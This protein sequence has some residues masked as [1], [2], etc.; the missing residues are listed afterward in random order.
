MGR[1]GGRLCQFKRRRSL[2]NDLNLT[3]IGVFRQ[4]SWQ[5]RRVSFILN[6]GPID[7]GS[8]GHHDGHRS[9]LRCTSIGF[10]SQSNVF[11][12]AGGLRA[13]QFEEGPAGVILFLGGGWL[14]MVFAGVG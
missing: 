9:I 1:S 6:G 14:E 8:V 5:L 4:P 11:G 2:N 7:Y 13:A 12:G 10:S 3:G